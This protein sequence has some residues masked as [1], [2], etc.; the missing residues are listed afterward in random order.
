MPF[1]DILLAAPKATAGVKSEV[2]ARTTGGADD[3]EKLMKRAS[4]DEEKNPPTVRAKTFFSNRPATAVKNPPLKSA[5]D[6]QTAIAAAVVPV[7]SPTK[8]AVEK[9]AVSL[10][11]KHAKTIASSNDLTPSPVFTAP[12][13]DLVLPP[14]VPSLFTA[15]GNFA[16]ANNAGDKIAPSASAA[17]AVNIASPVTTTDQPAA[18]GAGKNISPSLK[19]VLTSSPENSSGA[20]AA[21]KIAD[22]VAPST[23]LNAPVAA[24]ARSEN[25]SQSSEPVAAGKK[26]ETPEPALSA[27]TR[28]DGDNLQSEPLASPNV[29][30]VVAVTVVSPIDSGAPKIS[31]INQPVLAPLTTSKQISALP[32]A[33]MPAI[34]SVSNQAL[35]TPAN[36]NLSNQP[37]SPVETAALSPVINSPKTEIA[38]ASSDPSRPPEN[39]AGEA[40]SAAPAL[41]NISAEKFPALGHPAAAP[42]TVVNADPSAAPVNT[43]AASNADRF[44]SANT[45][46]SAPLAEAA[47]TSEKI[48]S[49][50]TGATKVTAK[51]SGTGVASTDSAMKNSDKVEV[52]AG[53]E[54]QKLPGGASARP[55]ASE[56]RAALLDF[57]NISNAPVKFTPDAALA[58]SSADTGGNSHS[59][60]EVTAQLNVVAQPAL[61]SANLKT[62]EQTHELVAQHALRLVE[63]KADSLSVVLKPD[64]GTELSLQLRQRNGAVEATAVLTSGDHQ[65]LNQHWADLQSRLDLRGVKLG[66][67]GGEGSFSSTNFNSNGGNQ[68]RQMAREEAADH[69][70]A[71]AE[72]A[73]VT[74]GASARYAP[75]WQGWESWA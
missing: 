53:L 42:V 1:I 56:L 13:V 43:T 24:T 49:R 62:V 63:T 11:K 69:A 38:D 28:S 4:T 71:F 70:S 5:T 17:V 37:V 3:F 10:E 59:S 40:R 47:A 33:S 65:L 35:P 36:L 68:Q 31:D 30:P 21:N 7:L 55:L 54:G 23:S 61:N 64:A 67:L 32:T 72:F 22:L 58:Y 48:D 16:V 45:G 73:A 15:A 50:V 12:P 41:E 18:T 25:I 2:S 8:N 51:K 14:V 9:T 29:S 74:G 34:Q 46:E 52:F 57:S 60:T 39:L 26:L 20:L 27:M 66:P 75:P 19:S 44:I 6:S